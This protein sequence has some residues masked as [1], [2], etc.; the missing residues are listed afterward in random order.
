MQLNGNSVVVFLK[1]S[2]FFSECN[3]YTYSMQILC[4]IYMYIISL[5]RSA[6]QY[7][8]SSLVGML[9][10]GWH[11][12][13]YCYKKRYWIIYIYSPV[14]DVSRFQEPSTEPCV[15]ASP[16]ECHDPTHLATMCNDCE[17]AQYCRKSCGLCQGKYILY[18]A[19]EST[20]CHLN[21]TKKTKSWT[22]NSHI[23]FYKLVHW[24]LYHFTVHCKWNKLAFTYYMYERLSKILLGMR[25]SNTC[26]KFDR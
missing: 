25:F 21:W 8:I 3:K 20:K 4:C 13:K 22:S 23:D 24:I 26:I 17:Y 19:S 12:N 7:H 6:D 11:S 18:R 10:L 5:I 14:S 16:S 15:D 1:S 9:V 2:S